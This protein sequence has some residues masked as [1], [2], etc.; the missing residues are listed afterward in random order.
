[1]NKIFAALLVS[2][3]AM[4][5]TACVGEQDD[6][7]DKS[8][9][10]RLDE[11]KGVYAQRLAA[12]G[13]K[14]IM[15]YYPT[16]EKEAPTGLGY[17]MTCAFT[18]DYK[19][20]VAMNNNVTKNTYMES[21]S[22][23]EILTDNG[24][25]LSFNT[26]ND[27]LHTFSAPE[28]IP[29]E[30]FD[31]KDE[32]DETGRGYEGDY[33]F[34]ITSLDEGAPQAMLKGKKRGTYNRLTRIDA[35]TD[36]QE[37]LAD[38]EAFRKSKF[39]A[40]GNDLRFVYGGKLHNVQ[41]MST[42]LPNI[43]PADGDAEV[44]KGLSPFIITKQGG[45]YHL[46][47]RD[48][49]GKGEEAEQ[50]FIYDEDKDQFVGSVNSANV[51]R[52]INND[53]LPAYLNSVGGTVMK[54]SLNT[55]TDA[56]D[57]YKQMLEDFT[58]A[59]KEKSST[60]QSIALTITNEGKAINLVISYKSGRSNVTVTY[61]APFIAK[62]GK[63]EIGEWSDLNNNDAKKLY[64]EIPAVKDYIDTLKGIFSLQVV[65]SAFNISEIRF[66]KD[67]ASDFWFS[68]VCK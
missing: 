16:N 31:G 58:K 46:R 32:D 3:S 54:F 1:M 53:E 25:V 18:P 19:V 33:E 27:V 29:S 26:Y 17:L 21:T 4:A 56:S 15:E 8:A 13:G 39:P 64:N 7:F 49:F 42:N 60:L 37:Y 10:E 59:L 5:F 36:F 55:Y 48:A 67:G 62:D 40:G 23:W 12:E 30:S 65:G 47:F 52:G 9:T 57:R 63:I 45:K 35:S 44:D 24:P 61:R 11:I 22:A 51:L 41:G 38:V 2:T 20:T 28:N 50:E 14:W 6:L 34:V 68:S 43:Y 66:E